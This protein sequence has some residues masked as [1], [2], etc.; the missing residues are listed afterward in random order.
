VS[1]QYLYIGSDLRGS[2]VFS[3]GELS[4]ETG[5]RE[6]ALDPG[7]LTPTVDT[8]G[9]LD[10]HQGASGVV[11]AST[12]GVI[13]RARL[14]LAKAALRRGLPVWLHWPH[15][16]AVERIDA[17]RL[18]S[19]ARLRVAVMAME[20]LA[21]PVV[22]LVDASTRL[23][24]GLAWVRGGTVPIPSRD[25]QQ[26]IAQLEQWSRAARP[27]VPGGGS[28]PPLRAGPGV[29]LRTDFWNR[30]ISGGSYGHTCYVAKE[31]AAT[32]RGFACLL[33]H[34][35]E[36]L[37][38]LGVFQVALEAPLGPAGEEAMIAASI[39]YFPMVRTAC[40]LMQPSYIYERLCLGNW[41]GALISRELQI[42]YL[43]EYNGS[44]I[45]MHRG[46]DKPP[47]QYASVYEKAEDFAFRQAAS[48]SVVSAHIKD[49]LIRRGI[50][51]RKILVNPN[52]ADLERYAPPS[53]DEKQRIRA[54]LGLADDECVI[55]FTGTFGW[56]HGVDV[57]AAA[58]PRLCRSAA[59]VKF[60]LIGDG[61]HK[62][63]LDGEIERH[64]LADRV[65]RV[66]SVSQ[67][68]GARLLKAC[69]LFV[70][71]H[72]RHMADGKFFGSPTK[73]FEY[74]AMAAGIVATDL[75]QIGEVLSP[76]LRPGD[77]TRGDLS[78]RDERAV[79]C[80]P[81]DV[82][83]FVDG[84]AGL[85][86]RPDIATALGRNARRAAAE[87]SWRRHVERLWAFVDGLPIDDVADS[88]AGSHVA[89]PHTLEWF[90]EAECE[91]YQTDAWLLDLLDCDGR[92]GQ[93][94]VEIGCGIG[95][96]LAQCAKHGAF[97][98]G[99]ESLEPTLARAE[100]NFR[101]RG[102]PGRFML[103]TGDTLP[104]ESSTF[105]FVY[106]TG[107][108]GAPPVARVVSEMFRLLKP[109]GAALLIVPAERS[110]RYWCDSVWKHGVSTG[111]LSR[112]SMAAILSQ[113]MNGS[114]RESNG[115]A[116]VYTRSRMRD[117]FRLF[118]EVR[119]QQL[120]LSPNLVPRSLR[121]FSTKIE[122]LAG[123]KLVVKAR[124]P[125]VRNSR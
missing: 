17:D 82:D 25:V 9:E 6:I 86:R 90:L 122:R 115:A 10:R 60:L 108:D 100:E 83:Q 102:L 58:L 21:R 81:G 95:T 63:L 37:D 22:Q 75:E 89:Q 3:T 61:T 47:L 80:T 65:I 1:N 114:G 7:A 93:Q 113:S 119:V 85:I 97:V 45:V 112:H 35:Y 120:H 73:I 96:D 72:N 40:R 106:A 30:I 91:R 18:H 56:W 29:Y 64:G 68:E 69:D 110:L 4:G 12:S 57:L 31:L 123:S 14:R 48:I 107:V 42:P 24:S 98:T 54:T 52:G 101:L 92:A 76:A 118:E 62:P 77:L 39:H 16:R 124:K 116:E 67:T 111:D 109:G 70:S 5:R 50:D 23:K 78:V 49:D 104:L 43:L 105:D 53:A 74:M 32:A 59:H 20:R 51:A 44:E 28:H 33:P 88:S 87:Y 94:V 11:I 117:L 13:D 41:V 19:L 103:W 8:I 79:L 27:V 55:G 34:Q 38:Q 84:V 99:A 125:H 66:G 46:S 36:L 15:E 2:A 26:I 71:P 121:R